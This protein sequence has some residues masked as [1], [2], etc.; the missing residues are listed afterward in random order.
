MMVSPYIA[1]IHR[2]NALCASHISALVTQERGSEEGGGGVAPTFCMVNISQFRA[3]FKVFGNN[4]IIGGRSGRARP[5]PRMS[6]MY[7][8]NSFYLERTTLA[9]I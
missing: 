9:A 7:H 4:Q 6:L 3:L 8:F 5:Y 1:L 2:Y